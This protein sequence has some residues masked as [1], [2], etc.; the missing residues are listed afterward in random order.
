[1]MLGAVVTPTTSERAISPQES[2][3]PTALI[4]DTPVPQP[5]STAIP[6]A[7]PTIEPLVDVFTILG[8]SVDDVEIILGTSVLVTPNNDFDD[9]LAG[10][11][12]R[13][14]VLGKYSVFVAY[15]KNGVA[16]VFQVLDG[17][18]NENYSLDEW[19]VFLPKFGI[20][21]SSRPSREAPAALYWDNYRGYFIAVIA[22]SVKGQP[23]ESIQVA[24]LG[25]EP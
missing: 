21:V 12:Y 6:T 14:Y 7:K 9:D 19:K 20:N 17:L 8:R 5:S 3:T 2:I 15:D 23:V 4:V 16:R 13:D 10:G 22:S 18:S 25:Y 1:M 24:Q 11:E